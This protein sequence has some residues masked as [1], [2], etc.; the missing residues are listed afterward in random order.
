MTDEAAK[1]RG[2]TAGWDRAQEG[3]GNTTGSIGRKAPL[4]HGVDFDSRGQLS[5]PVLEREVNRCPLRGRVRDGEGNFA[6]AKAVADSLARF[7]LGIQD[8]AWVDQS[9]AGDGGEVS[10]PY[11]VEVL[12]GVIMFIVGQGKELGK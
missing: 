9:V 10:L 3:E 8:F 4:Y 6:Q 2:G 7:V 11:S 12:F 1:Y 5:A